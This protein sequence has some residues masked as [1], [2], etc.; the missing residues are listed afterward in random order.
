MA[1][2]LI[3]G[4]GEETRI[5]EI[6]TP[7]INLGRAESS[8]AVL[9][10]P[11]VSRHHARLILG[12]GDLATLTDLGSLNGILVNGKPVREHRLRDRDRIS[13]GA[14]ELR[15]DAPL[16]PVLE[17]ATDPAIAARVAE[18]LAPR[19]PTPSERESRLS[20]LESENRLL[21][22]LLQVGNA[23]SAAADPEAVVRRVT[24]LIF[25]MQTVERGFVMLAD[26]QRGFKP[27]L[28][29]Y[30]DPESRLP[31]A[32]DPSTVV[33][34]SRVI[35]RV[36]RERLPLLIRNVT[37]DARFED[38]ESLRLSGVRS[39]MCA[40]LVVQDRFL[41][42]FYVDC[43]S[44]PMAF[45][46]EQLEIFAVIAAETAVRLDNACAYE[47]LSR[48]ALERRA[49]ERFL[50]PT[51]VDRILA[52][53]I[54]LRLGGENQTATI[55]FSDLRDFTRIAEKTAPQDLVERL[56][57]FFSE[58]TEV[59][60][61]NGGTLDKYLGDGMMAVFGAPIPSPD[62]ARRAVKTAIEMHIALERLNRAWETRGL[63]P[64]G[65]GIGINTGAVTAGNV[66]SAQRMDYTVIGDAVNVAA[67]LCSSA[68]PGQILVAEA[69]F[70]AL[71]GSFASNAGAPIPIKGHTASVEVYEIP[72]QAAK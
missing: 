36:T 46:R 23:V 37:Q 29:L 4:P 63:E 7:V 71:D 39:A 49:L 30:R 21:R 59:I 68:A 47:E 69:S 10:H 66:G 18:L 31:A 48:R 45:D 58:M 14:Y 52:D 40:P 60:F 19:A 15:Y 34:S 5:F 35:E 41:G 57:E 38:S 27:A 44:K 56:N 54:G 20:G 67:R 51:V 25:Q 24:E 43:L 61:S 62:D 17:I 72:W 11:S 33:L 32:A 12:P 2:L 26:E 53:P 70:R 64:L 13:I 55:L 3:T 16:E 6:T 28:L 22:L 1:R 9:D 50:S 42:I 65:M 8:D